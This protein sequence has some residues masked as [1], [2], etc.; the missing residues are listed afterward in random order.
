MTWD[1]KDDAVGRREPRGSDAG[2][3]RSSRSR[4]SAGRS[5]HDQVHDAVLQL[6][7]VG[8]VLVQ[9]Y[10]DRRF[11]GELAHAQGLDAPHVARPRPRDDEPLVGPRAPGRRA[12]LAY[13]GLPDACTPSGWD[14]GSAATW[15]GLGRAVCRGIRFRLR[16]EAYARLQMGIREYT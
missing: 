15:P 1:A 6:V 16:P 9:G 11:L 5:A 8:H 3:P 10:Q 7:R 12:R 14:A 4:R 2:W 13:G